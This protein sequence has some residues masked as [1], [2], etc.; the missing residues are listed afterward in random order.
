MESIKKNDKYEEENKFGKSK[1]KKIGQGKKKKTLKR[2]RRRRKKIE[3][4]TRKK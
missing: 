4:G 1:Y 2:K 3:S